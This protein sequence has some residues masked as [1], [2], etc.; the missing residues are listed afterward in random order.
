[1]YLGVIFQQSFHFCALFAFGISVTQTH[2]MNWK[3]SMYFSALQCFAVL[4]ENLG[5]SSS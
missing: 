5:S 4:G 3:F 2:K 1:M